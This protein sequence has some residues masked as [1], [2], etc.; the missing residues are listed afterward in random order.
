MIIKQ[1]KEINKI[2]MD[3]QFY[4]H[5]VLTMH[6]MKKEDPCNVLKKGVEQLL[7]SLPNIKGMGHGRCSET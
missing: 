3:Q 7:V 4:Q 5:L 6:F 1:T 2:M